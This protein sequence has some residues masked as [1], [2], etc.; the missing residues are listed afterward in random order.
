MTGARPADILRQLEE[1]APTDRD[2]LA[3]FVRERDQ[4]AF[5]ELVIRHGPVVL[6]V[7][8]RVTCHRQDAEDAFQATFLILAR[9][10]SSI[11][12]PEV[13][14]SWLHGVALR[15]AQTARRS[16]LRRRRWEAVVS[17][18]PDQPTSPSAAALDLSPILDEEL[19]SLPSLYR[20][21]IML[22]DLR[23]ITREEAAAVLG[24]PEG[25]LSS[26]LA[27]GRKKLAARLAKRGITLSV[28]A[29]PTTLST[30]QA[31]IV[32]SELL[33]K[34]CVLVADWM[35]G[36][37]IPKP[38]TKLTEGGMLVRK[39]LMIGAFTASVAVFGVIYAA[40]PVPNPPTDIHQPLAVA[41]KS[42]VA[43]QPIPDSNPKPG[44]KSAVFSSK[45]KLRE[46]FD[47]NLIGFRTVYWNPQGT[48]L[49]IAG[50]EL[51]GIPVGGVNGKGGGGMRRGPTVMCT[52]TLNSRETPIIF[53]PSNNSQL[54]GYSADGKYLVTTI[55]EDQLVSGIHRL[56]L[57][58]EKD[59]SRPVPGP[60]IVNSHSIDLDSTEMHGFAFSPDGKTFRTVEIEWNPDRS[61]VKNLNVV[62]MDATTGKPIKS[63]LKV[64]PDPK[65][66][67]N[68]EFFDGKRLAVIEGGEKVTL[69]DVDRSTKLSSF[70]LKTEKP[71]DPAPDNSPGGPGVQGLGTR[72]PGFRGPGMPGGPYGPG[73]SFGFVPI[74]SFSENGRLLIHS[75]GIGEASVINTETG[76]ELPALEKK[77][78]LLLKPGRHAFGANGQLLACM[79]ELYAEEKMSDR[80]SIAQGNTLL[81]VWDT[82]SGKLL[83]T[84]TISANVDVAF[85]PVRPILAVLEPNGSDGT[86]VGFWDFS[87]PP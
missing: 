27:N 69:Y 45:P 85:N 19:A 87:F 82:H 17:V 31:A 40:Q 75:Y 64:S 39:T 60:R 63:L 20:D 22:C 5:R 3:R 54:T 78:N 35:A 33:A 28:A 52:L 23:G 38:I 4:S 81:R 72:P 65:L 79:G 42:E 21:A 56:D 2:L 10:A 30:A 12:K 55:N 80:M 83:K 86:R 67:L 15:V 51:T 44:D 58:E 6:G 18:M 57:W 74:Q 62:E 7:C 73:G 53:H 50:R 25:T 84:W 61:N 34:T 43:D 41:T 47:V 68:V 8:R 48:R 36:G 32:P 9:K 77:Q 16:A 49:A 46:I 37:A 29:I 71:K 24:V 13:I 26:R 59:Q 11:R 14:G 1:P 66:F 70:T 76:A